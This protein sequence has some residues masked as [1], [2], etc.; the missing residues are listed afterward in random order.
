M[1]AVADPAG[2]SLSRGYCERCLR[3]DGVLWVV[4]V[5]AGDSLSDKVCARIRRL[6]H[7]LR[8]PMSRYA[9]WRTFWILV[10]VTI[11]IVWLVVAVAPNARNTSPDCPGSAYPE[12]C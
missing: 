12:N 5:P 3:V 7:M 2:Q 6:C 8:P 1:S 9:T 11:A 10:V 4:L